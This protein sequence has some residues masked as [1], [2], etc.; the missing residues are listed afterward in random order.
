MFI[1]IYITIFT[2]FSITLVNIPEYILYAQIAGILVQPAWI[3]ETYRKKQYG[4]FIL[5]I[6]FLCVWVFGLSKSMSIL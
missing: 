3:Y 2:F 1:Q 6:W 4:M 5:S